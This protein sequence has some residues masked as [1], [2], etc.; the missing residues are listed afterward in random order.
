MRSM[1]REYSACLPAQKRG[2]DPHTPVRAIRRYDWWD[3]E[4][5]TGSTLSELLEDPLICRLM[6]SD[7]VDPGELRALFAD[8]S[9]RLARDEASPG[10]AGRI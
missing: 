6:T 5:Y 7:G 10:D 2:H 9:A 1:C 3:Q 8:L 4:N